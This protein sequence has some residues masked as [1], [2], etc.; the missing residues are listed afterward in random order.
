MKHRALITGA[1]GGIGLELSKIFAEK[2]NDLILVARNEAKLSNLK[3]ELEKE[4]GISAEIIAKDLTKKNAAEELFRETEMKNLAS[5]ILVNNAGFGSFGPFL[6]SDIKRQHDMIALNITALTEL[7]YLY[8]NKMR[9]AGGGKILNVASVAAFGAGPYMSVYYATKAFVLSFSEALAEELKK[10]GVT[11]TAICPGPTATGFAAA[12]N[13]EKSNLFKLFGASPA[14]E[15]AE[16][17]YKALM[18]GKI[19]ESCGI[20]AKFVNISSRLVPRNI[21]AKLAAMANA[22][23]KTQKM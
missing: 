19:M 14:K 17:A 22:S 6:D 5:D 16:I 7:A 1:S 23:P 4:Y 8:G 11:V 9:R 13:L 20:L 2:G 15:V 21:F 18:E 3:E 10:D 12:A